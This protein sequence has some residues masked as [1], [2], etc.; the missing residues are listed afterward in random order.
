[1]SWVRL[2]MKF[3]SV[4]IVCKKRIRSG[5]EGLWMRGVGVKHI[6]CAQQG[7]VSCIVCGNPAGCQQC[8][9]AEDCDTKNISLCICSTCDSESSMEKY[10]DAVVRKFHSLKKV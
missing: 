8:S 5:Q 7:G 4:C 9:L 2:N 1:M 6:E 3:A 10:A